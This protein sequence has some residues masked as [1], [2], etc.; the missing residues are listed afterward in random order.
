[1]GARACCAAAAT[2]FWLAP[3]SNSGPARASDFARAAVAHERDWLCTSS[4]LATPYLLPHARVLLAAE[5]ERA[6]LL[7]ACAQARPGGA[8]DVVPAHPLAR[9][10]PALRAW[11][12]AQARPRYDLVL[13]EVE[14]PAHA[15]PLGVLPYAT[16]PIET[17]EGIRDLLAL[18]AP[19]G[20]LA[21]T[22][23]GEPAAL[24]WI[25]TARAAL[26]AQG[27]GDLERHFV[28]YAAAGA[29]SVMVRPTPFDTDSLLALH[30]ARHAPSSEPPASLA[31]WPAWLR[32]R[33]ALQATAGAAFDTRMAA[34]LRSNDED[35]QL[36]AYAFDI[37]AASD[38][39][40]LFFESTRRDRFDTWDSDASYYV[41]AWSFA[42][43]LLLAAVLTW[44]AARACAAHEPFNRHSALLIGGYCGLAFGHALA[45]ALAQQRVGIWLARPLDAPALCVLVLGGTAGALAL[46]GPRVQSWQRVTRCGLSLIAPA[47]LVGLASIAA[48][49]PQAA[50][51]WGQAALAWLAFGGLL[52]LGAAVGLATRIT[53][54]RTPKAL[55]APALATYVAALAPA[56]LLAPGL[57]L[58]S[59][60][61][62]CALASAIALAITALTTLPP[63]PADQP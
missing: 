44:L 24:R 51:K 1:M 19:K 13:V 16:A 41:L 61:R 53:L 15:L 40:P 4:L 49:T 37:G 38:D 60:Y 26:R 50:S 45:F 58:I 8:V 43:A 9:R 62:S 32:T 33:P 63:R 42:L 21:A 31:D 7:H 14:A 48:P 34:E 5:R 47:L 22:M 10:G 20:T 6:S 28:V 3:W 23:L 57:V 2:L 35:A 17:S 36:A 39:R 46:L 18:L 27:A 25:H 56:V 30:E 52:A 11:A 29:Y 55:R 12:R 59:G 54:L